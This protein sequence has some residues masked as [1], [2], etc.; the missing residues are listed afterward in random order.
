MP[1]YQCPLC[2]FQDNRL[3]CEDS[4]RPYYQCIRCML[5]FVP[6]QYHLSLA[7]EKAVYDLH[8]N[9]PSDM[10]YRKFLSRFTYPLLKRLLEKDKSS[11]KGLD[12]GCGP[13]PTL[14]VM[15]EEEGHGL[16]LYDIFYQQDK[17]V[18]SGQ[19]DFICATEVVEHFRNPLQAFTLLF[20]LL[21]GDGILAI[22]TKLVEDERAFR[23]WHYTR[24]PTHICFYYK[25]TFKYLAD[26]FGARVE[27]VGR[28]VLM[29]TM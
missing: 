17:K 4:N 13:G 7:D 16:A 14:S 19:Y 21:S 24:D 26:Q 1:S 10:G 2:H 18:L 3:F 6:T 29:M 11:A 22:M 8:E 28:D 20:S 25:S 9:S 12:F 15:L 27:F 23:T 5:V